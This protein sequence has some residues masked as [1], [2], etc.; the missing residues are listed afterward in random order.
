[1]RLKI[2]GSNS[3][4]NAYLLESKTDSLLIECGV[5]FQQIK[6]ALDWNINK[7]VGCIV[8]HG[9]GDHAC[10]VRDLTY[11]GINVY[12]TGGTCEEL[13]IKWKA[14]PHR[15]KPRHTELPF[16][17][18][19]FRIIAFK[20]IH[21]TKEPCGFLIHHAECGV[22]LFLTDTVY[23]PFTFKGLNNIIVE[24][25]YCDEILEERR[26]NGNTVEAV[27]D[28]VIE[29]H[30]SLK[31]CKDL[32]AANDLS[33]VNNIVLIHLSDGHSHAARFK[34]EVEQ[35]TGKNVHVADAGMVIENFEMTPF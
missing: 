31:N 5:R 6:Q 13:I 15:I 4:G 19:P 12:A 21:D 9:H 34:R 24:A 35:L 23:S 20:T 16:S 29:S 25:N 3:K 18:G 30:M 7:L 1:M 11:A 33:K 17:L 14:N 28:R 2:I 26:I 22:V 32:L 8:T 27:R 10:G